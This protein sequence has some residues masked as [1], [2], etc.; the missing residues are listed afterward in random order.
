MDFISVNMVDL[1]VH[2][3]LQISYN[4]SIITIIPIEKYPRNYAHNTPKKDQNQYSK[5]Q[6]W[7]V[8]TCSVGYDIINNNEWCSTRWDTPLILWVEIVQGDPHSAVKSDL[9]AVYLL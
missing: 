8:Y 9:V 3:H 4:N 1:D 5:V 6:R 2:V 7:L